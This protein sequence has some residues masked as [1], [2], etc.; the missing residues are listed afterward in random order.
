MIMMAPV[1]PMFENPLGPIKLM[2]MPWL[3]QEVR[4]NARDGR[5]WTE[6]F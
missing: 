1:I 4:R 5:L 2:G 6:G 3:T